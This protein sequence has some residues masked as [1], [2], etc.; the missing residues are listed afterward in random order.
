MSYESTMKNIKV[1]IINITFLLTLVLSVT[2]R[3]QINPVYKIMLQRGW[4]AQ[5]G[6]FHGKLTFDQMDTELLSSMGYNETAA[7]NLKKIGVDLFGFHTGRQQCT[8]KALAALSDCI[9]IGTVNRVEHPFKGSNWFHTI[10]YVQVEEYLRNDYD[11]PKIQIPILIQSGQTDK[12]LYSI[13]NGEDTLAIGEHV[14]LYLSAAGLIVFA[15]ENHLNK[16]YNY[17]V[18][19]S[20]IQFQKIGMFDIID[21]KAFSYSTVRNLEDLKQ[22]I[23]DV[24]KAVNRSKNH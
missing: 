16:L 21:G 18:D 23:K 8:D 1:I 10:A 20:E 15:S 4:Y 2:C 22:D 17:L 6:A 3:A 19:D 12:G 13:A 11:L 24:L 5:A 7:A 14:L 9:I